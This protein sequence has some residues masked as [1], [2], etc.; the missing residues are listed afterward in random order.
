[1]KNTM[2]GLTV[3]AALF[4]TVQFLDRFQSLVACGIAAVVGLI[5]IWVPDGV[6]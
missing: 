2:K 5:W 3:G 6:E 4:I 1:M